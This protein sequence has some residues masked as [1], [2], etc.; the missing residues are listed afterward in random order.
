[1]L[2]V[3][4]LNLLYASEEAR[5]YVEFPLSIRT[6]DDDEENGCSYYELYYRDLSAIGYKIGAPN[7]LQKPEDFEAY[8]FE[9][10]KSIEAIHRAG[11]IHVDLYLSN[12]MYRVEEDKS[13]SIKIIDWDAAHCLSE[14]RFSPEV[15]ANLNNHLGSSNVEF[16]TAH[17]L[18]Y[19]SVLFQEF[20]EE[21][22]D[23]WENL[24]S[25]NKNLID[26]AFR[27]LLSKQ[28]SNFKSCKLIITSII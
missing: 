14:G 17:D 11:V 2:K 22:K 20:D 27:R 13:V 9:Y 1:M 23:T 7:R 18:L 19:V 10:Q 16:G 3:E 8:C 4:V 25:G 26:S 15:E 24:S 6:P 21:E 5:D 28:L 12:V